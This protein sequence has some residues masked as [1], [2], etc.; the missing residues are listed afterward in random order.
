[1]ALATSIPTQSLC[2]DGKKLIDPDAA[3]KQLLA[4]LPDLDEK[5]LDDALH[6]GKHCALIRRHLTPKQTYAVNKLGIVG[7]E[8]QPDE[9]RLYPAGNIAAHVVG[10][11]DIDNK[12][13][14][15]AEQ[16]FGMQ[17]E[18]QQEPVALSVDLRLQT[19]MHDELS[20][21]MEQFHAIGAG[22]LVMD[23]STGEILAMTSLPDFD[24]AHPGNG[25]EEARFNRD[26][27]GVYEMGS[28]FK[29]FNTAL[30]LD[31][32]LIHPGDTFNTVDPIDVGGHTIH[33]FESEKRWLNVAEIFT[34][35]SNIGSAHMA[36][37]FGGTRQRAFLA[38]LGLT[39]KA[40]ARI[41]G[42][43]RAAGAGQRKIGAKPRR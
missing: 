7:L 27:L 38:R 43:R 10:Y 41:A 3:E 8:F 29:I 18:E 13:L 2:V 17:L 28:T 37:I 40:A 30:A 1:M 35:S 15:G 36:E 25:E 5:K 20:T 12:G 9:R 6:S 16:E 39:E 22:G 34:H 23:I 11:T 4:V 33:D 21:A 24:P 31:S 26:T 32:G 42:S 19:I 14:A